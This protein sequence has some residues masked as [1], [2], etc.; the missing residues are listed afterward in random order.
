MT[1]R[2]DAIESLTEYDDPLDVCPECGS[3]SDP[4]WERFPGMAGWASPV[5][6]RT[7]VDCGYTEYEEHLILDETGDIN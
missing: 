3:N 4:T 5:E 1:Y 7:C 2:P 6:S